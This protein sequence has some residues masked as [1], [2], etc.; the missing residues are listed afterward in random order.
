LSA[1]KRPA[2]KTTDRTRE[3]LDFSQTEI[4]KRETSLG[5]IVPANHTVLWKK[6]V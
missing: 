6:K 1:I 2:A 3:K 4:T 5:N